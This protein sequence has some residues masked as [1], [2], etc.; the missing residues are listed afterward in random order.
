[1][2]NREREGLKPMDNYE[3]AKFIKDNELDLKT[4]HSLKNINNDDATIEIYT[5][6]NYKIVVSN[7]IHSTESEGDL[8]YS[9]SYGNVNEYFAGV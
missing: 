9:T 1:M 3:A 7:V 4:V 5:K 8:N 6:G 2:L